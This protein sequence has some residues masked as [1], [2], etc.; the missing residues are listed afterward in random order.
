MFPMCSPKGFPNVG[1]PIQFTIAIILCTWIEFSHFVM[2]D[3]WMNG[4]MMGDFRETTSHPDQTNVIPS[5]PSLGMAKWL[6]M[7]LYNCH[8]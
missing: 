3:G 5:L 1:P 4:W 8:S 6:I 2:M 7:L